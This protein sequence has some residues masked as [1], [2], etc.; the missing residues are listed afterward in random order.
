MKKSI[1]SFLVLFTLIL[2]GTTFTSCNK[3]NADDNYDEASL[4]TRTDEMTMG[5]FTYSLG[6]IEDLPED[7]LD[8]EAMPPFKPEKCFHLNYPVSIQF[9]DSTIIEVNS[10]EELGNALKTWRE[11]NPHV[12]GRP[13]LVYPLDV[14]LRDSTVLTL[15]SREEMWDLLKDCARKIR[16]LKLLSCMKPVFPV[17]LVFPDGSTLEVNSLEEMKTALQ[18]W[19]ENNPGIEGHPTI[20]FPFDIQLKNG[21]I[22]TVNNEE[23]LKALIKKCIRH[24]WMKR[25]G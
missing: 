12:Q 3:D 16:H 13:H 15:N 20:Q 24:R 23:E 6:D 21:D 10:R 14:T 7:A 1:F 25:F 9:P 17:T 8:I 2:T 18:E 22:V 5:D 4:F 19:R 11:N